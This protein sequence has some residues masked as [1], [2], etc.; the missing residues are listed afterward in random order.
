[1]DIPESLG[2]QDAA[3]HQLPSEDAH[4]GL[5]H[6]LQVNAQSLGHLVG[7][8]TGGFV[9]LREKAA[10]L[11]GLIDPGYLR[12]LRGQPQQPG[13]FDRQVATVDFDKFFLLFVDGNVP[14]PRAHN[15]LSPEVR[16]RVVQG[17]IIQCTPSPVPNQGAFIG[18]SVRNGKGHEAD[19]LPERSK[20]EDREGQQGQGHEGQAGPQLAPPHIGN[21][22]H[23]GGVRGAHP[24]DIGL[25][26][27]GGAGLVLSH[28][29]VETRGNHAQ[30]KRGHGH[31]GEGQEDHQRVGNGKGRMDLGK[32][33]PHDQ[34]QQPEPGKL[35]ADVG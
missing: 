30:H 24:A 5:P 17:G 1:M 32:N 2:V 11:Q 18:S 33:D 27:M 16:L 10:R 25:V 21:P 19:L 26:D 12:L 31:D 4:P 3:H 15:P 13:G 14:V 9:E 29:P 34:Q 7:Q 8:Q 28:M 22:E 23:E 35:P 20:R 6:I